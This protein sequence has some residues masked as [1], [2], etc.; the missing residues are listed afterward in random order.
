MTYAN[1]EI[2]ASP[3]IDDCWYRARIIDSDVQDRIANSRVQVRRRRQ[4]RAGEASP[5]V[6]FW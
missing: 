4:S 2:V 3:W 1:G 5:T 6:A